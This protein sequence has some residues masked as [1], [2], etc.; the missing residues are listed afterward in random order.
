M[1]ENSGTLG[2]LGR[3]GSDTAPRPSEPVGLR[4]DVDAAMVETSRTLRRFLSQRRAQSLLVA[5]AC[6][7]LWEAVADQVGGKLVRP[8]LTVASYLGAPAAT[9]KSVLSDLRTGKR[10]ELLR[11]TYLLTDDDGAEEVRRVM[12]R[13][14]ARDHLSTFVDELGER[15]H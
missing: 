10:T 6:A 1:W 5:P 13:C 2:A 11:L 4:R 9:G 7:V 14:G 8:R 15:N 3:R 12:L